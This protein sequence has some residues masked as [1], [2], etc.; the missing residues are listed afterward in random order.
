VIDVMLVDQPSRG[1]IGVGDP[2]TIATAA[3]VANAVRNAIGISVRSI[4]MTPDRILGELERAG[5][6]N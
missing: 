3:A 2:P 4:P 5:G 1:V 6:T